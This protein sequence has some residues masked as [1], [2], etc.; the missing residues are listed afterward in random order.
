MIGELPEYE[1]VWLSDGILLAKYDE[2]RGAL[3]TWLVAC[4][5]DPDEVVLTAHLDRDP[6]RRRVRYDRYVKDA[7]GNA[8]ID[9]NTLRRE[10]VEVEIQDVPPWP[11]FVRM[12]VETKRDEPSSRPSMPAGHYDVMDTSV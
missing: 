4:G 10:R 2:D 3:M 6:M 11:D 7:R 12:R 1:T 8:I 9:G 5:I